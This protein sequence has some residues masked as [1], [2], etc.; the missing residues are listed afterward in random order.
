VAE[1]GG[2]EAMLPRRGEFGG[3]RDQKARRPHPQGAG[4]VDAALVQLAARKGGPQ[5]APEEAHPAAARPFAA[6]PGWR[7]L[8][9]C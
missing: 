5:G 7:Q 6:R 1:G 3:R 8:T 9:C 2:L 4:A